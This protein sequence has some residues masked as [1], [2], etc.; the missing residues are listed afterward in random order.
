MSETSVLRP[1]ARGET[2]E[3][4]TPELEAR[5]RFLLPRIDA[6]TTNKEVSRA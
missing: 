5:I 3:V 6:H 4:T 2:P 1:Q